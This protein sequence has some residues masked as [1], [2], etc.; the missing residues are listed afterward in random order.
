MKI[1]EQWHNA[2]HLQSLR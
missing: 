2:E 1:P